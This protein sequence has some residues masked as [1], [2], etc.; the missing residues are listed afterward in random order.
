MLIWLHPGQV[1]PVEKLLLIN[2]DTE[3]LL[4]ILPVS[5]QVGISKNGHE[6]NIARERYMKTLV[7]QDVQII[8][9]Q[10]LTLYIIM[11]V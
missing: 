7:S 6:T 11:R 3:A 4:T 2:V 1:W 5:P 10:K 8:S 9:M